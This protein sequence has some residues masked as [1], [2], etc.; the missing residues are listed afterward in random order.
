MKVDNAG[1][2]KM[3]K[4]KETGGFHNRPNIFS[5]PQSFGYVNSKMVDIAKF[6]RISK[7]NIDILYNFPYCIF[8]ILWYYIATK[9]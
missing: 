3:Q 6:R 2:K 7:G 8:K 5:I 1:R 4:C 9:R